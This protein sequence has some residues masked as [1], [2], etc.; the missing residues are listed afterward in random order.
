MLRFAIP[1]RKL[2]RRPS[3][4]TSRLAALALP[5]ALLAAC[6]QD[7]PPPLPPLPEGALEAVV[8]DPGVPREQLA[9][10]VD[11]LFTAEG[12]GTTY[13]LVVMHKG[14]VVAERYGEGVTADTRFVGWS[15]SKTVTAVLVGMLVADGRVELDDP[16]PVA[17][18]QRAGDPRGEITLRHLL[19]MRSGLRHREGYDPPY[20]SSEVRM[21]YLAGH[22]DMAAFAEAQA[23]E[24]VPGEEFRYSTATSVILADI[25]TD[26]IAPD[27]TP[28]QRQQAMASFLDARLA[29]P[30]GMKSMVG[31]YDAAGT[32]TGGSS[33]WATARDWGKFGE[34][35]RHGGSV[36]GAQIVPRRWIE[37]MRT[38]SP[39][40]PDY[41]AQTWLNRPS[42]GDRDELFA[43][44]GP[45]TAFAAVGHLGQY[46]I[47]SP[48][49]SLTVVRL[50][51]TDGPERHALVEQLADIVQLYP[52]R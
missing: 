21:L 15:M 44:R 25:A 10:A 34:F 37:F 32:L 8:T 29:A 24:T 39:A 14:E 1:C 30:L 4:A 38:P 18:W 36:K 47:V 9:R 51:K 46:V 27:G 50:G 45:D 48:D 6:S 19:Q 26:L 20:E 2:V 28:A 41:G 49:Q 33:I 35:L 7:G 52:G 43:A 23:L 40:S 13:A 31:E 22:D 12:I 11:D 3:P 5:V 42:G 17:S 16:A